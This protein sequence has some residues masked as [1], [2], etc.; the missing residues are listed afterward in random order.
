MKRLKVIDGLRGL[1]AIYVIMFHIVG[2]PNP[3]LDTPY[4][5]SPVIKM[6]GIGVTL[7]FI[8]SAFSLCYTWRIHQGL[9]GGAQQ[10]YIRRFF[11]IAPLFYVMLI[12]SS[13]RNY[14]LYGVPPTIE[15]L[16]LSL[17]FLFNFIPGHEEGFVWASWT[18]GVEMIFYLIFPF[19]RKLINNWQDAF[20]FLMVTLVLAAAWEHLVAILPIADSLRP[21][22]LKFGLIRHIPSFAIGMLVFFVYEKKFEDKETPR[23]TGWLLLSIWIFLYSCLLSG[24]LNILIDGLYW[25]GVMFSFL[26][27]GLL[28][29]PLKIF[30]NK[31]TDYWGERSYS[32]YLN[33]PN[34]VVL[35]F[36]ITRWIYN[37]DLPMT[38]KYSSVL[39]IVLVVVT[40]VSSFTYKWIEKPGMR[41]GKMFLKG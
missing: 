37:Q 11:R 16:F 22:Y 34:V 30:D 33:H 13:F 26:I 14:Y 39:A 38:V 28:I 17:T 24:K 21:S 6:G 27:L 29:L 36:P 2:M 3:K 31:L 23:I 10:F 5:V 35:C 4:W 32:I 20:I 1:A 18:I 19:L 40:L 7:F 8:L 41:F 9:E 12:A 25:Q 15:Q